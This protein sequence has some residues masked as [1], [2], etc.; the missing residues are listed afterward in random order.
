MDKF[1]K[2]IEDAAKAIQNF[3]E[4]ALAG[5]L[6]ILDEIYHGFATAA[7][8][9]RSYLLRLFSAIVKLIGAMLKLLG[10]GSKLAHFGQ[11]PSDNSR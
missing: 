1:V 8:R 11:H 6:E 10:L 7:K 4:K 3:F 5:L 9:I 2:A